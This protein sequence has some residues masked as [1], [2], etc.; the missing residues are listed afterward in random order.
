[1]LP[2]PKIQSP[3]MASLSTIAG[4]LYANAINERLT[5]ANHVT[6]KAQVLAVLHRRPC[7]QRRHRAIAGGP[8]QRKREDNQASEPGVPGV[9]CHGPADPWVPVLLAIEGDTPS[10]CNQANLIR[11]M[12]GN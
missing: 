10:G 6:W 5:K 8:W 1:M 11:C 7:D 12:E 3:D 4:A 9:V 2:E